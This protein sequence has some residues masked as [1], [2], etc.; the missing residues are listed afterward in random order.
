MQWPGT[1]GGSS[2]SLGRETQP[3]WQGGSDPLSDLANF[4]QSERAI[5]AGNPVTWAVPD[6]ETQHHF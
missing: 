1:R 6:E 3:T 2:V 5:L 4:L